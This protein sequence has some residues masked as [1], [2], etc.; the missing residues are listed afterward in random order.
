MIIFEDNGKNR[1]LAI[2]GRAIDQCAF[3]NDRVETDKFGNEV[4]IIMVVDRSFRVVNHTPEHKKWN[5]RVSCYAGHG[6]SLKAK[7][8]TGSWHETGSD[9]LYVGPV[10]TSWGDGTNL[11]FTAPFDQEANTDL[12]DVFNDL[13]YLGA[14]VT[15][16]VAALL[17]LHRDNDLIWTH[18][19]RPA[20]T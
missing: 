6:I 3:I 12:E 17:L 13:Y 10:T 7:L 1:M 8:Y 18:K 11:G 5:Q 9:D 16:Y 19:K 20:T 4:S 2:G 15:D 14:D